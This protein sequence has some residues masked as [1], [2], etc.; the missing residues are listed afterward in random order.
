MTSL[1]CLLAAPV[2]AS[3]PPVVVEVLPD[4]CVVV[5]VADPWTVALVVIG[6]GFD[7]LYVYRSLG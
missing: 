6:N 1:L 2:N 3:G 4:F 5:A 7:E